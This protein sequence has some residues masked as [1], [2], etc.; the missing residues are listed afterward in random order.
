VGIGIDEATALV[1]TPDTAEVLG[2]GKVHVYRQG[3]DKKD[4]GKGEKLTLE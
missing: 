2:P 4:Y 1:V 3:R